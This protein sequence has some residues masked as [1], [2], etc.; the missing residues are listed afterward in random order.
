MPT[1]R[2]FLRLAA[3]AED[4]WPSASTDNWFDLSITTEESPT[5][6]RRFAGHVETSKPS[7]SDPATFTEQA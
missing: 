7:Q 1:R 3:T 6:L 5:F 2:D 4:H